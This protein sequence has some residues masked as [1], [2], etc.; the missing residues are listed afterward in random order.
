MEGPGRDPDVTVRRPGPRVQRPRGSVARGSG[1]DAGRPRAFGVRG[2]GCDSRGA[3]ARGNQP[4]SRS[5][6]Q[7]QNAAGWQSRWA[8][9]LCRVGH[10]VRSPFVLPEPEAWLEF[11]AEPPVRWCWLTRV[12]SCMDLQSDKRGQRP[13]DELPEGSDPAPLPGSS[14]MEPETIFGK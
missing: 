4:A 10:N 5:R 1:A 2:V 8:E 3:H 12:F 14:P 6:S 13:W 9:Q 11:R 7:Q